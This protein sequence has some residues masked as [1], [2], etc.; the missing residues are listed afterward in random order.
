MCHDEMDREI[1]KDIFTPVMEH[2][3]TVTSSC[4]SSYRAPIF[5]KRGP[6][7]SLRQNPDENTDGLMPLSQD[8]LY[9]LF[10]MV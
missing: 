3:Y 8:R 4:L 5:Q 9:V 7:D 2:K 6:W 1:T 10:D